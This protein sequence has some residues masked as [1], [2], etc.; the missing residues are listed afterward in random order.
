MKKGF[1]GLNVEVPVPSVVPRNNSDKTAVP[2][3]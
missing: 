2:A 1:A 3:L